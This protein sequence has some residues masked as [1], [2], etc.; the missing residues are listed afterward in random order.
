MVNNKPKNRAA[1]R[2]SGPKKPNNANRKARSGRT[3]V[4]IPSAT[5]SIMTNPAPVMVANN[6]NHSIT[7][8]HREMVA[9]IQGSVGFN[10]QGLVVNPGNEGVFPWLAGVAQ[11]YEFYKVNRMSFQYE[12]MKGSSSAGAVY[13]AVDLDVKDSPPESAMNVM[14]YDNA[15]RGPVW[16][17]LVLNL[18][19][20]DMG[21]FTKERFVRMTGDTAGDSR[22]CDVAKILVYAAGC[23]DASNIGE[24]YVDYEIVLIKP[25]VN[26]APIWETNSAEIIPPVLSG[27][28]KAAPF[29]TAPT[30]LGGLPVSVNAVGDTLTIDRVGDYIFNMSS[31]GTGLGANGIP[32]V[33]STST[34]RGLNGINLL[35][36]LQALGNIYASVKQAPGTFKIDYSPLATTLSDFKMIISPV[37]SGVL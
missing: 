26:N 7:V 2:Q 25:Q 12:T 18:D 9:L 8:R 17:P 14:S 4:A 20:K 29:G 32:N 27:V 35:S 16:S 36:G 21:H 10:G 19:K 24:L 37:I 11:K 33:T 1:G 13:M 34:T 15:V 3:N 22:S 28:A 5:S 30:I 31:Y 23:A 6:K